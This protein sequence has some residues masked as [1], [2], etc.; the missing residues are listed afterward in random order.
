MPAPYDLDH[1][2]GFWMHRAFNRLR[3]ESVKRFQSDGL[4]IT[5]EQW[6]ILVRLWERDG[7]DQ[8]ELAQSTFRDKASITRM[9]DALEK[10]GLLARHP[11]P[12]DRRRH[13]IKLTAEGRAFEAEAVPLARAWIQEAY[14]G[15]EP[16]DLATATRV[17]RHIFRNLES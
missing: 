6:A 17:M 16:D 15:L 9:I 7:Q 11:D 3:A 4:G 1:A 5:P 14:R 8:T 13:V 10:R 12:R 2:L